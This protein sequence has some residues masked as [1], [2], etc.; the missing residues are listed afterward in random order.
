MLL[1]SCLHTSA[2]STN[3]WRRGPT[4]PYGWQWPGHVWQFC[5]FIDYLCQHLLCYV[6]CTYCCWY[7]DPLILRERLLWFNDTVTLSD[8]TAVGLCV[9]QLILMF[10]DQVN[11]ISILFQIMVVYKSAGFSML[12]Q[13][14]SVKAMQGERT[15]IVTWCEWGCHNA[16][17][18]RVPHPE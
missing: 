13:G 6:H 18:S 15:S 8:H 7:T 1:R 14:A 16:A 11:T 9:S 2:I 5:H 17:W 10:I 12:R 3:M 4:W